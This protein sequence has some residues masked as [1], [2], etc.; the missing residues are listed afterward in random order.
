MLDSYFFIPAD[1]ERFIAKM[2][3]LKSDFFVIDLEDS[4]SINNKQMAYDNAIKLTHEDNFFFRAPIFNNIYSE[5]QLK[6]LISHY[7]GQ[8]VIPKIKSPSDFEKVLSIVGNGSLKSIILV[9]NPTSFVFIKDILLMYNKYIYG[10]GFGSHDFCSIMGMKHELKNLIHYK[11]EL[12]LVAKAFD[13]IYIDTVDTNL[14]DL[15]AFKEECI[16]AFENGAEGKVIIHPDQL[17]EMKS[18]KYL[19]NLEIEKI[20]KVYNEIKNLNL[21]AIDIIKLDGEIYEMPHIIR[22]KKLYEKLN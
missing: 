14:N 13:K 11:K 9:E 7:N 1:K 8:I 15:N 22:I 16:F 21:N 2:D 6:E 20:Y 5:G 18:I 4:V 3:T 17:K 12:L 10:V 19:S